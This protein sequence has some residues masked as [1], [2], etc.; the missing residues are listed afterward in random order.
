MSKALRKN[1]EL[2]KEQG[3][4]SA[5]LRPRRNQI[6]ELQSKRDKTNNHYIPLHFI[7]DE[8]TKVYD[9]L[10]TQSDDYSE[11][12]I[13]KEKQ[14]YSWFF[15]LQSMY[16]H[17]KKTKQY[18]QEF[19]AMVKKQEQAIREIKN[20]RKEIIT[21]ESLGD[22]VD[23]DELANRLLKE[24]NP[25]RTKKRELRREIGRL[26]SWLRK[27]NNKGKYKPRNKKSNRSRGTANSH[28][29][30]KVKQKIASGDSFSLQDLDVL[31]NSGGLDS[32]NIQSSNKRGKKKKKQNSASGINP[33][34][35]KRGTYKKS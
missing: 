26:E 35:G 31:L 21:V 8:I 15:E 28:N 2:A 33:Q 10:T 24:L 5:E 22:S 32:V 23:F 17:S 25:L 34:R 6:D 3:E 27:Q 12:T 19:L 20:I 9:K 30:N 7:R 4:L 1:S 11:L 16:S 29:A 18:H 13:Q 14:L